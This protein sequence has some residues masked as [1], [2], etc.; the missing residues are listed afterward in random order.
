MND[1]FG[2]DEALK[3]LETKKKARVGRKKLDPETVI[4]GLKAV[5]F[6]QRRTYRHTARATGFSAKAIWNA[7]KPGSDFNLLG[8]GLFRSPRNT[9]W[10]KDMNAIQ[11]IKNVAKEAFQNLN[12]HSI[13]D[14]VLSLYHHTES[15][16]RLRGVIVLR[17]IFSACEKVR[18][19]EV[20]IVIKMSKEKCNE[21]IG[22][23]SMNVRG[24][25]GHG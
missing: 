8:L 4:K 24:R 13:N 18:A 21:T 9:T 14:T 17:K 3:G 22:Q 6:L 2:P 16:R 10:D 20:Y 25:L 15:W 5:P 23:R 12:S 19:A 7:V 11:D 1:I